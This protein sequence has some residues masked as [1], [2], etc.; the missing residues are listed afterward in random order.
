MSPASLAHRTWRLTVGMDCAQCQLSALWVQGG[1]TTVKYYACSILWSMSI[2]VSL[3][4]REER[5]AALLN[6]CHSLV[7][8]LFTVISQ[9]AGSQQGGAENLAEVLTQTERFSRRVEAFRLRVVAAADA[10]GEPERRG[11]TSTG[12]WLARVTHADGRR[13]ASDASLALSL[14]PN[15]TEAQALCVVEQASSSVQPG[16]GDDGSPGADTDSAGAMQADEPGSPMGEALD[17]R[18]ISAEHARVITHAMDGLPEWVSREQRLTC[19]TELVSLAQTQAPSRLRSAARRVLAVVVPAEQ[20][21]VVNAHESEQL[22][23]EEQQAI[24]ATSFW[25]R[26]NHDGTSTGHFVVPTI[27]AVTLHKILDA[28][29]APRR[30]ERHLGSAPAESSIPAA[31]GSGW[32][33]DE[34]GWQHRRGLAFTQILEHLPTDRLCD[35]TAATVVIT[36]RLDDLNGT[37]QGAGHTDAGQRLSP[38]EVRRLACTSGLVP[39][40]L[41]THSVPLDLGRQTRCYTTAQRA[42]LATRHTECAATGC[43]RPFAWT[44]IHHL[45]PWGRGGRTDLDNAIPLCGTHHRLL[46]AGHPHTVHQEPSD[47]PLVRHE[48]RATRGAAPVTLPRVTFHPRR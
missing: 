37:L 48:N 9:P 23:R 15:S 24:Q 21:E 13:A 40:V 33:A 11:Y 36:M 29:T 2:N 16:V 45:T 41:G 46:H 30:A 42:A 6:E 28:M 34:L 5:C 26:N 43:D 20:V 32:K 18:E 8:E 17:R 10:D 27:A 35:K 25:L 19:E 39:A 3:T 14:R 12:A 38:G 31:G 7:D 44:E 1:P 22:A 47:D 4:S